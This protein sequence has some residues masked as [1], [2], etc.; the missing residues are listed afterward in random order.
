MSDTQTFLDT[1]KALE[2]HGRA[3]LDCRSAPSGCCTF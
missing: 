2:L 3:H 1:L